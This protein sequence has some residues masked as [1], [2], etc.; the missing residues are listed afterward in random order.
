MLAGGRFTLHVTPLAA[1]RLA[2]LF[3]PLRLFEP[4]G[5][6]G[7]RFTSVA[8]PPIRGPAGEAGRARLR[9]LGLSSGTD[10]REAH[11]LWSRLL[12]AGLPPSP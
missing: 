6:D 11:L 8:G 4:P 10:R 9:E 12:A 1:S 7:R 5:A 2:G 3:L